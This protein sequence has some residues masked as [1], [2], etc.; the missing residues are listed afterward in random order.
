[1]TPGNYFLFHDTEK[2]LCRQ[3]QEQRI[4]T[5]TPRFDLKN[6]KGSL[7]IKTL[8]GFHNINYMLIVL[9]NPEMWVFTEI[10]GNT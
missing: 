2:G 7:R 8:N 9:Q 4:A 1:M 5:K 6:M 10:E 3:H